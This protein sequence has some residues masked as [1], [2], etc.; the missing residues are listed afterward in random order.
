MPSV[1]LLVPTILA[2]AAAPAIATAAPLSLAVSPTRL[3]LAGTTQSTL[4]VVNTSSDPASVRVSVGTFSTNPTGGVIVNP[5][6]P[7]PRSAERWVTVSPSVLNLAPGES[8]QVAVVSRPPHVAAPGDHQALIL[9][10]TDAPSP[11]QVLIRARVGIT[12][13]SRV[14]GPL[15]RRL[16]AH[17]VTVHRSGPLRVIR[18]GIT[19]KGNVAERFGRGQMK[20]TLTRGGRTL[21]T[22]VAQVR[23]M[24][25]GT[26]Q[27]I[28]FPYRGKVTGNV[29]AVVTVT[30]TPASA[31]GPGIATTPGRIVV[32]GTVR[33]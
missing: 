17:R 16:Q 31:A 26:S 14:G 1:R 27:I 29:R 22:V 19:N 13:L 7:P 32:S 20:V 12:L 30:P 8:A 2:L 21:G 23:T 9:L 5:R 24:L 33:L 11:G 18:L 25:P 28:A 4:N 10:T 15:F 3:I 6:T